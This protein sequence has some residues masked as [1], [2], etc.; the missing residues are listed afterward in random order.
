MRLMVFLST[1]KALARTSFK[2]YGFEPSTTF[3]T[4]ITPGFWLL[5]ATRATALFVPLLNWKWINPSGNTNTYPFLRTF[6][7]NL[8]SGFDVTKP[9]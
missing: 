5:N 7:N 1:W 3:A 8:L 2:I 4:V 9:T 6:V